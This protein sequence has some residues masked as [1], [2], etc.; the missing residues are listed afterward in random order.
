VSF[1]KINLFLSDQEIKDSSYF[2]SWVNGLAQPN[3]EF[4]E[5]LA[6]EMKQ[7]DASEVFTNVGIGKMRLE[8]GQRDEEKKIKGLIQKI[9][10][11]I[12]GMHLIYSTL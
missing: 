11:E 2:D 12:Q 6:R 5:N 1:F 4:V 8:V 7:Y 3:N 10:G 9:L